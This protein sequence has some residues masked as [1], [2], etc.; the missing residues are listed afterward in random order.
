[1]YFRYVCHCHIFLGYPENPVVGES[2]S[3]EMCARQRL[4]VGMVLGSD[5]VNDSSEIEHDTYSF[6]LVGVVCH[7]CLT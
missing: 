6:F 3:Q 4:G 2:Q 1:M 7:R 5:T